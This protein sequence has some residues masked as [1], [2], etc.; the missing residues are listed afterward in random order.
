M[1]TECVSIL[2]F[3]MP[4]VLKRPVAVLKRPSGSLDKAL[5]SDAAESDS[6]AVTD[7]TCDAADGPALRRAGS[8][9]SVASDVSKASKTSKAPLPR[10]STKTCA[11]S[12]SKKSKTKSATAT[13]YLAAVLAP[14]AHDRRVPAGKRQA[15]GHHGNCSEADQ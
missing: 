12:K 11:P 4:R 10:K 6:L 15:Y 1:V 9:L 13:C 3:A 14:G 8:N 5:D 2:R 7:A